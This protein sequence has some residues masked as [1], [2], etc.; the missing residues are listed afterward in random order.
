MLTFVFNVFLYRQTLHNLWKSSFL[1]LCISFCF[2]FRFFFYTKQ[3]NNISVSFLVSSSLVHSTTMAAS[4]HHTTHRATNLQC[5]RLLTANI[6]HREVASRQIHA[7][8]V[9]IAEEVLCPVLLQNFA[10]KPHSRASSAPSLSDV[11]T[12]SATSCDELMDTLPLNI[13]FPRLLIDITYHIPHII[14]R[15]YQSYYLSQ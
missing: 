13:I 3:H 6:R 15:Y 12:G 8:S 5:H 11:F 1:L 14:I 9:Y 10:G 2:F 4:R 7:S